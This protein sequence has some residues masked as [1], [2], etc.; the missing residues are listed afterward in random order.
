MA[1]LISLLPLDAEYHIEALQAV[2]AACPAYWA[3]YGLLEPS[4]EQAAADLKAANET[5][6]RYILGI[7]QRVDA[8]DPTA[9]A[10]LI[11]IIDFRLQ[12]PDA[13]L[14]YIGMLMVAQPYQRQG[15]AVQAWS[16]L[17]PWLASSAGVSRVRVGVEQFN[18]GALKF[19]QQ[20]GFVLTG[21]SNRMRSGERFIRQLYLERLL[22]AA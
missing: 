1:H 3:M 17:A 12:W 7:V 5:P 9:G 11:G 13:D 6:G 14:A 4:A 10:E 18:V 22:S 21:E 19:W 2:Y 15:V 16:L 8:Q 20:L